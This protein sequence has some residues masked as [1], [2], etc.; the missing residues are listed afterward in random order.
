MITAEELYHTLHRKPFQP[1]RIHVT[2]GR[3]FDVRDKR[4]AVVGETYFWIGFPAPGET[5]PIYD[6]SVTLPLDWIARVEILETTES[7]AA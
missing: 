4:L 7:P 6:D 3:V 2:D 5:L 1:F